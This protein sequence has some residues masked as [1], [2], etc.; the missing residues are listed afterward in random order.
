M[1]HLNDEA[2]TRLEQAGITPEQWATHHHNRTDWAGDACGCPDDRCIGHHH[3]VDEPCRCLPALIT[4]YHDETTAAM[5]PIEITA[6]A[7]DIARA[8]L[9]ETTLDDITDTLNVTDDDAG[10][11]LTA[12]HER[13]HVRTHAGGSA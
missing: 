5:T 4:T 13:I 12:L 6:A 1:A 8:R 7:E 3:D 11:I 2:L 10:R 9:A